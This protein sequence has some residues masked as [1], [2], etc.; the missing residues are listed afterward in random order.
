MAW[1]REDRVQQTFTGVKNTMKNMGSLCSQQITLQSPERGLLLLRL[2]DEARMNL[3]TYAEIC[4]CI[5]VALGPAK[6]R[7]KFFS[8]LSSSDAVST[9]NKTT[10]VCNLRVSE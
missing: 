8:I 10:D 9:K 3:D 2:R 1:V 4:R 7:T 5:V 6:G